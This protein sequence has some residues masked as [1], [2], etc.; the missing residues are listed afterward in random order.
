MTDTFELERL[1]FESGLKKSY[2][3]KEINLS[4][5]GFKNK[6]E[7]R[8]A[9]TSTEIK[10]LC[11]ILNITKLTDKERIFFAGKGDLKSRKGES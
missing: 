9:F 8:S 2:I 11:E 3:A 7:N 6:C 4:R 5:Q 1:I 10:R